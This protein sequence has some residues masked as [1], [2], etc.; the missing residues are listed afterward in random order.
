MRRRA[1]PT[2]PLRSPALPWL[3]VG[4]ACSLVLAGPFEVRAAT[5]SPG[6]SGPTSPGLETDEDPD[7]PPFLRDIDKETYLRL[8][9]AFIGMLRG[10]DDPNRLPSPPP[11]T[12]NQFSAPH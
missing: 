2:T 10:F 9:D 7:I 6:P 4:L 5:P 11:Q 3:A 8:R 12:P 1:G